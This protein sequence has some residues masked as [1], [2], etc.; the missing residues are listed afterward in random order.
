M[1]LHSQT[2]V[3]ADSRPEPMLIEI[4]HGLI[5][6][7]TATIAPHHNLIAVP[8]FIDSHTHPLQAG[9]IQLGVDLRSCINIEDVLTRLAASGPME[10]VLAFNFEPDRLTEQ[11]WPSVTELDSVIPDRPLLVYRVDGH[12]A[13]TNTV[14]RKLLERHVGGNGFAGDQPLCGQSYET[15][16][17]VFRRLLL[18]SA[19]AEA[20][21]LAGTAAAAAGVT[22]IAA[23]IGDPELDLS[24]WQILIDN[25]ARMSVRAIPYLQTWDTTVALNFGLKQI[26]GCLLIDG[27]FGS[28]T[29]WLS[30]PYSDR[31]T[32]SGTG[33]VSPQLLTEFIRAAKAN[34]L[35]TA[36]H[37]IGDKA[38][39]QVVVTHEETGNARGHRIEHAELL[40]ETMIRRIAGLGIHLAVQPAFELEWGGPDRLYGRR[41]GS[42][43]QQTNPFRWLIDAGV[44]LAGGSDWPVTPVNPVAG[45]HAAINHPNSVQRIKPAEAMA[46]FTVNAARAMGIEVQAGRIAPGYSADIVLLDRDPRDSASAQVVGTICRGCWTY[47]RTTEAINPV[48]VRD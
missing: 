37:A 47:Q 7:L 39:E 44:T 48:L 16:S 17:F 21:Q 10:P 6:R 27:S 32:E 29:A 35:Q 45:I 25:L 31:P 15:A 28:H 2:V 40:S 11:R 36:F 19:A 30:S 43:W 9:L 22:T 8:G 14:G 1:I 34:G 5:A 12:S 26:G 41:L 33:Y 24:E 38:I 18:P 42:R 3:T 13:Q 46:M 23:M 4:E 20:L